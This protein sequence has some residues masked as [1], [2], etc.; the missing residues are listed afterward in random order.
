VYHDCFHGTF[1]GR[2]AIAS[3]VDD[4]FYRT[5][6]NFHWTFHDPVFDGATLY[7]RYAFSY[8]SRLEGSPATRTGFEG[9]AIMR[10]RDG[11]VQEYREVAHTGPVLAAL[12]FAPER[13]AAIM[14]RHDRQVWASAEFAAHRKISDAGLPRTN[15]L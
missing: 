14:A 1:A 9:V 10:L 8:R 6:E 5:A 4:W 7:A 12:N 15:A 2:E 3:L 13:I 11:L